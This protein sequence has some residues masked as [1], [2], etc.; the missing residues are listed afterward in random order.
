MQRVE[1]TRVVLFGLDVLQLT[2]KHIIWK[3]S[4]SLEVLMQNVEVDFIP[5]GLVYP[6]ALICSMQIFSLG[7]L[8]FL[9]LT[10]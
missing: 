1:V 9:R 10:E 2:R 5:F 8:I 7:T 3:M 4:S 6:M